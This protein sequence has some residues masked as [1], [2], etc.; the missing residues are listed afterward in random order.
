M[1]DHV[2]KNVIYIVGE[3]T[4]LRKMFILFKNNSL[5]RFTHLLRLNNQSPQYQLKQSI[6]K[7]INR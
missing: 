1:F 2:L 5:K 7:H 4:Q 6:Q 3:N